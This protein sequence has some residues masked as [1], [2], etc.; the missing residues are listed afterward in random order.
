MK[1]PEEILDI[2][3]DIAAGVNE[4]GYT[5]SAG[6]IENSM[7]TLLINL[8]V[9]NPRYATHN[10]TQR[11]IGQNAM[12]M[13]ALQKSLDIVL[14]LSAQSGQHSIVQEAQKV[15][16]MTND[17]SLPFCQ[18]KLQILFKEESSDE[19]KSQMVDAMFKTSMAEVRARNP[20][21]VDLVA[22]M[23]QDSA[24]QV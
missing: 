14:G 4:N 7:V 18:L 2:I 16:D 8:F 11:I 6:D 9:R 19:V 1:Y 3:H 17:F 21:W 10:S 22:L 13:A 24:R 12:S 23:S 15:I 5:V 20:H